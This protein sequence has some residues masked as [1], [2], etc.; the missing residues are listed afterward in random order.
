MTANDQALVL[1]SPQ[2]NTAVTND[3]RAIRAPVTGIRTP[4]KSEI[5]AF[6]IFETAAALAVVILTIILIVRLHRYRKAA[7]ARVVPPNERARLRLAE[8]LRMIHE[9]YVFCTEVSDTLRAYLEGQFAFHAPER[10][11]EEF[12]QELQATEILTPQQKQ[13]LAAFLGQCDL[14]KFARHVP[15]ESELRELHGA[16]IHLISETEPPP[17]ASTDSAPP[18][19]TVSR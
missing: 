1:S 16:A 12:L 7:A 5:D 14:V 8:A 6:Q 19:N 4:F 15:N 17:L 11:T 18:Q 2:T 13:S 9:P 3:I 10:T